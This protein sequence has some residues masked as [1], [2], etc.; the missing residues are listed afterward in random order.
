MYTVHALGMIC[1]N[2]AATSSWL[3]I[4][5]VRSG[6][7]SEEIAGNVRALAIPTNRSR[8]PST[9]PFR[10]FQVLYLKYH[11]KNWNIS[12]VF[13]GIK[14][15][16]YICVS[17]PVSFL[18]N[19]TILSWQTP[20]TFRPV[21]RFKWNEMEDL[22]VINLDR[23]SVPKCWAIEGNS[24]KKHPECQANM[25]LRKFQNLILWGECGLIAWFVI[26]Y[27]LCASY[28]SPNWICVN[29]VTVV[30]HLFQILLP[31]TPHTYCMCPPKLQPDFETHSTHP[32]TG[33]LPNAQRST[34][35]KLK[36]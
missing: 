5:L 23:K 10:P 34:M 35:L 29:S 28:T 27:S 31:W 7:L 9:I 11:W 19:F 17:K 18:F 36:L 33:E 15:W 26:I 24:N 32:S 25:Q 12:Y 13:L 22:K 1:S 2:H 21:L 14:Y 8:Y 6:D 3:S 16:Y 20:A 4:P 30:M